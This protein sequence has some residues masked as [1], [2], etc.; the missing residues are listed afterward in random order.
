MLISDWISDGCSSDPGASVAA[1]LL[2]VAC[3]QVS[4][5]LVFY[6]IF[7]AIGFLHAATLYEPAFAVIARRVGAG[8]A[9]R[10][11]TALTL[12]GGFASTVFIRSEEHRLNSSH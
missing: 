2:L 5:I 4:S 8:N 6:A 9:R 11:I 3:S 7:A 10:G 1:G 12:W